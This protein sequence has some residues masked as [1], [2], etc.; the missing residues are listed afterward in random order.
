MTTPTIWRA[1]L[2]SGG[3]F[4]LCGRTVS[5]RQCCDYEL[6]ALTYGV[7]L[8]APWLVPEKGTTRVGQAIVPEDA[9]PLRLRIAAVAQRKI[10]G[11]WRPDVASPRLRRNS[12]G[13]GSASSAPTSRLPKGAN[14][15]NEWPLPV[16]APCLGGHLNLI[17]ERLLTT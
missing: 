15:W 1:R 7:V 10:A 9:S 16:I 13:A 6:A 5:A 4:V 3:E 14:L 12:A 2:H 11:G 8:F 17:D